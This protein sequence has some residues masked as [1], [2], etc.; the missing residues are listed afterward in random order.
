MTDLLL[1][2][3]SST[4]QSDYRFYFEIFIAVFLVTS[5]LFSPFK[6][7]STFLILYIINLISQVATFCDTLTHHHLSGIFFFFVYLFLQN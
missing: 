4:N 3:W 7:C 5:F 6:K 2:L 1:Y